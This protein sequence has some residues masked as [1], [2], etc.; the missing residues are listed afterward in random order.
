VKVREPCPEVE[1]RIRLAEA[2]E[3]GPYTCPLFSST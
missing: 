1:E 3:A 2:L